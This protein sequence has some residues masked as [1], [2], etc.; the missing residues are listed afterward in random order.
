MPLR[1]WFSG[2][3]LPGWYSW[4]A[5]VLLTAISVGLNTVISLRVAHSA[6]ENNERQRQESSRAALAIFC[7]AAR[8]Q[9]NVFRES[10]SE[11]GRK[12]AEAWHDLGV[13]FGCF[14]ER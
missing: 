9:E 11:V 12:A 8:A 2:H 1:R 7:T 10:Q 14:R 13:T 5:V 3:G 4:I 6:I